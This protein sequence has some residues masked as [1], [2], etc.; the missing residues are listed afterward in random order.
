MGGKRLPPSH[1]VGPMSCSLS[2]SSMVVTMFP[3]D[4]RWSGFVAADS[5]RRA[6]QKIFRVMRV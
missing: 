3:F 6:Q 5:K 1:R 4:A 2:R